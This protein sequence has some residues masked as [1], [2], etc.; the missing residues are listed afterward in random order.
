M[1]GDSGGNMRGVALHVL[2][3]TLG[4]IAT[5]LS[6]LFTRHLGWRYADPLCSLLVG[7][8]ILAS[9]LPLLTDSAAL[10]LLRTP[11][12][13]RGDG[14]RACLDAVRCLP[15][16]RGVSSCRVWSHTN[17]RALGNLTVLASP[18][19]NECRVAHS[20]QSTLRA[21]FGIAA[22]VQVVVVAAETPGSGPAAL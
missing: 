9:A 11:S 22:V 2:A 7:C 5:V 14:M 8:V 20:V 6:S 12:S 4:S 16:V 15:Y 17:E 19:A 3:D 13:L 21:R 1:L 10:L 18:G